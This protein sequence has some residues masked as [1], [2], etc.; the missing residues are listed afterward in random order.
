MLFQLEVDR[1]ML[2]KTHGLDHPVGLGL[3]VLIL[4]VPAP[5]FKIPEFRNCLTRR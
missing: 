3:S 1:Q 2:P 5:G 4:L